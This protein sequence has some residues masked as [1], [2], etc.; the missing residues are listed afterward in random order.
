MGKE[1]QCPNIEALLGVNLKAKR[2]RSPFGI[3]SIANSVHTTLIC[4]FYLLHQSSPSNT[5]CFTSQIDRFPTRASGSHLDTE[6]KIYETLHRRYRIVDL[7][8]T[9]HRSLFL[10]K[11][12]RTEQC[13]TLDQ[14][15]HHYMIEH[16]IQAMTIA[17]QRSTKV[18]ATRS[19]GAI[20]SNWAHAGLF[21]RNSRPS[22]DR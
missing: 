15:A 13:D 20:I 12:G 17:G 6:T 21:F 19:E 4:V 22:A 2:A 9:A 8:T 7:Q 5:A 10:D 14:S 11:T 3:A 16:Y 18:D 1:R